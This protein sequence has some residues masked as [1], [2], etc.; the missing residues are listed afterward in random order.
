MT[1]GARPKAVNA[2][3]LP[4]IDLLGAVRLDTAEQ[5]D[6]YLLPVG[7]T[8]VKVS[9]SAY[10][11]LRALAGGAALEE[12]AQALSDRGNPT[13]AVQV[14]AAHA[15][16]L[17]K[18]EAAVANARRL[19]G[20]F[21]LAR[22]VA[23]P[24]AVAR[25]AAPIQRLFSTRAAFALLGPAIAAVA[26]VCALGMD[27]HWGT[28]VYS[29]GYLLFLFSLVLHELG[30]AAACCRFGA[31]P[32]GIGFAL[33]LIYPALYSDV[34]AAWALPRGRRVVVDL[35]GCYVQCIVGAAFA[36][37]YAL[38][39]W[40]PARA[41][42]L[43][44]AGSMVFSLN[45]IFK[46][47][48]YWVV[49]DALGVVNLGA[50][51]RRIAV[52]AWRRLCGRAAPALPWRRGL[53]A[54]LALY[55]VASAA[56]WAGFIWELWPWLGRELGT[57]QAVAGSVAS[58]LSAGRSPAPGDLLALA[59]AAALLVIF[60]AAALQILLRAVR[61]ATARLGRAAAPG[62]GSAHASW[63]P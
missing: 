31:R 62:R 7:G 24:R 11:L 12:V 23:G 29:L 18:L 34:S 27:P 43:M 57:A 49:A 1:P 56:V 47:D 46:F 9:A 17:A 60:L 3:P 25:A 15:A 10:R 38:G 14:G 39:G 28:G 45:P 16:V 13:T 51:P 41:A 63:L 53:C 54:L 2:A 36:L 26:W 59:A 6:A 33:Y 32:R 42:V 37:W 20:G 8:P 55:S 44:I 21:W 22:I 48:G 35:A 52:A 30:H 4:G 40:A 61:A 58:A 50:Q 19:T 5:M